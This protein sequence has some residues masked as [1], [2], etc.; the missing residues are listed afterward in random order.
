MYCEQECFE[1]LKHSCEHHVPTVC[2]LVRN[3]SGMSWNTEMA[4]MSAGGNR[5]ADSPAMLP[6]APLEQKCQ[7]QPYLLRRV[8][9][10]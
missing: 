1:R 5:C 10:G 2:S 3:V 9:K 4:R 6:A 7:E 8:C